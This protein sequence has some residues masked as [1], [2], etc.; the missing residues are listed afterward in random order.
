MLG[1]EN[2]S[3]SK[4]RRLSRDHKVISMT[5]IFNGKIDNKLC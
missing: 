2:E 3:C 5:H 1:N 4:V